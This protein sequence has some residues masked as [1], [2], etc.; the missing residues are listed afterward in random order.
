LTDSEGPEKLVSLAAVEDSTS[1]TQHN[2]ILPAACDLKRK[3]LTREPTV[4]QKNERAQN[5]T[6]SAGETGSQALGHVF[7]RR[8]VGKKRQQSI[9]ISLDCYRVCLQTVRYCL[10]KG[11]RYV[12]EVNLGLLFECADACNTAVSMMMRGATVQADACGIQ[13]RVRERCAEMC[14]QFSDDVQMARCARLCRQCAS[15]S[16]NVVTA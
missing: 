12:E 7:T 3:R 6:I 10:E 4:K 2:S 16:D 9:K 13:N 11:G 14:E 1:M 5:G 15:V 8:N